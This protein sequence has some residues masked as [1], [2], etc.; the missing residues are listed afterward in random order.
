MTIVF[1]VIAIAVLGIA[2][3][4]IAAIIILNKRKIA[5]AEEV[6]FNN[7]TKIQLINDFINYLQN[8][9]ELMEIYTLHIQI[10]AN[11]IRNENIGPNEYGMFRCKDILTM[12]PYKVYLGNVWGLN[13]LP[14]T[15]WNSLDDRN[16]VISQY[17]SHL[18]SNLKAIKNELSN[19]L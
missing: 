11:N 7:E 9:T 16:L 4:G 13:T 5:K 14:L 2:V 12:R 15:K 19:N 1:S 3:L 18:I 10:W 8:S 17:K 6:R